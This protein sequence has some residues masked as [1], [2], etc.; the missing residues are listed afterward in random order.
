M[1]M[2]GHVVAIDGKT[3]DCRMKEAAASFPMQERTLKVDVGQMLAG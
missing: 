2:T 3:N 1:F